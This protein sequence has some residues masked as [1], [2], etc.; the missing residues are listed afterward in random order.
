[1][2]KIQLGKAPKNF[3][4][5]ISIELLDGGKGDVEFTFIYRT[6]SEYAKLMDD[7][8]AV[9]A[10]TEA[11]KNETAAH[12]FERIG[13]GTVE[14]IQKIADGWDLEEDFSAENIKQLID[15]YPAITVAAS[16]TYRLAILEGR[17]KN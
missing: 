9:E 5:K 7:T 1:M 3:K 14:F 2:A 11:P 10:G 8:L 15:T 4:R 6:R 12:A 16:E 13:E 17:T